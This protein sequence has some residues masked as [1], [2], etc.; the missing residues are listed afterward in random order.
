MLRSFHYTALSIVHVGYRGT[1]IGCCTYFLYIVSQMI[2]YVSHRVSLQAAAV[3]IVVEVDA[4]F[5]WSV[6]YGDLNKH[7]YIVVV[8]CRASVVKVHLFVYETRSTVH[9]IIIMP[10]HFVFVHLCEHG[11]LQQAANVAPPPDKIRNRD[12]SSVGLFLY[13]IGLITMAQ[14]VCLVAG[15]DDS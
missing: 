14:H 6:C 1:V 7:V 12:T 2:S 5:V 4:T 9:L 8:W 10:H 11:T 3:V 15:N 13:T